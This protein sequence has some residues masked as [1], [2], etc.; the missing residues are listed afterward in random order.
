MARSALRRRW[1]DAITR[2]FAGT[3]RRADLSVLN[4]NRLREVDELFV[5]GGSIDKRENGE[6][7]DAFERT[8]RMMPSVGLVVDAGVSGHA[9]RPD[10]F[11]VRH[12]AIAMRRDHHQVTRAV[13]RRESL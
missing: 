12:S 6:S 13:E 10:T 7:P 8:Q 3:A 4:K 5:S 1:C 2:S 11:K 9:K